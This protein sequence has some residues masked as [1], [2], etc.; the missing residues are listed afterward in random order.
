MNQQ[1]HDQVD[2]GVAEGWL[3]HLGHVEERQLPA[4]YAGAKLFVYPSLYEGF[5]L[6]PIEAMASG[7][8]VIVSDRSCLPEVCG[9]AARFVD[10]DNDNQFLNAIRF[11]LEDDQWREGAVRRGLERAACYTWDR[12]IED[13]VKVYKGL[14]ER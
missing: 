2:L 10:P 12:C 6:P 14:R 7:V 4:L 8:P 13:T 11:G 5:G 9:S 3:R 1:I